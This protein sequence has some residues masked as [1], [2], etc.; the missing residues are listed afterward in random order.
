MWLMLLICGLNTHAQQIRIVA[1]GSNVPIVNVFIF[2]ENQQA[3]TLTDEKGFANVSHFPD[4]GRV[5][6][7]HPSY[8]TVGLTVDQLLNGQIFALQEKLVTFDQVVIAANRW[9]QQEKDLSQQIA[10]ISRKEIQQSMPTTSADLLASSGEVFVQK[11]QLGGGSPKLR[12]FSA[13]SVLL[14]IDNVRMN[15]AIYRSGN[16]QNVINIDPLFIERAEIVF[17]PGSV[18]YG[19]DALGGVMDFHT[20]N[21]TW[22]PDKIPEVSA[23]GL[24]KYGSAAEER[25]VHLNA[26]FRSPK[27]TYFGGFSRTIQQDLLAGGWRT[28][29]YKGNFERPN[30][31]ARINGEDVLLENPNKDLQVGSGYNLWHT[32]HKFKWRANRFTDVSYT[33]H[34]S[35]TSDIPRYDRLVTPLSGADSLENAEWYYGPQSWTMHTMQVNN[36]T[37]RSWSDQWRITAAFQDYEES[38]NDRKFGD[39]RLRT[40]T[41]QVDVYAVSVDVNKQLNDGDLFYGV[42]FNLNKVNSEAFRQDIFSTVRTPATTRYPDDGST[43]RTAAVYANWVHRLNARWLLNMGARYS[44][45]RLVAETENPNPQL[46][47]FDQVSLNNQAVNGMIGLV[48][49]PNTFTKLGLT[50]SSGFRAPNVDDVGKIFEFDEDENGQPL[51]VVPNSNLS[52]EYSYNQEFSFYQQLGAWSFSAVAFNTL[53]TDPIVRGNFTIAGS[54][55]ASIDEDDDATTPET[56]FGLRAQV[57]GSLAHIYGGSIQVK[58]QK[59]PR[60]RMASSLNFS[61]GRETATNEPLRHTTPLFGQLTASF[62][63]NALSGQFYVQFSGNRWREKIPATEINDKP[64]LYT[65]EGSPGWFTLNVKASYRYEIDN[66][67]IVYIFSAGVENMLDMH[68]RPYSS[69]ISAPGRNF[70]VSVR[71]SY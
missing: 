1:E 45:V 50:L 7:Q 18:I 6:L 52:P 70:L 34:H 21:P 60:W 26:T 22:T 53:L 48:H 42:E 2:H 15:N 59:D 51:L 31:A 40:R 49:Q 63:E 25:T 11:S 12:G 61:D 55:T 68:Y 28:N 14:V 10:S 54:P 19:S 17:G 46:N 23:N 35:S 8:Q 37:P 29:A 33:F 39:S 5:Y 67:P 24:I 9:E 4:S 38:R 41:E 71:I 57:N 47:V 69:G 66:W 16:L 36:I 62:E 30:Y 44:I 32:L 13:N 56:V 58:F 65:A 43:Y 27:F 64:Y 3:Q 20:V